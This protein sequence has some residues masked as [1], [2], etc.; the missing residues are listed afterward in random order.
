M[1]ETDVQ[2][3]P[4]LQA[5]EIDR[6]IR[7]H[8][9]HEA[10][11]ID[12][13]DLHLDTSADVNALYDRLEDRIRDSGEDKWF[14]VVNYRGNRIAPEAW[15]AHARRGKALN[16]AHS[17]GTVRYDA[18]P[19]TRA[20]IER[21]AGTEAFDANLFAHRDAAMARIAQMPSR[22]VV[23]PE[24][25]PSHSQADYEKR[26]A[27]IDAEGI[28]DVDLSGL[29]FNHSRDVNDFYDLAQEMIQASGRRWY[30]LVNY[31]GTR[32][33]PEAWVAYARRGKE[34]NEGGSLGSVRYATGSETEE[35][36]RMRAESRGFRPNVRNTRAEA[37]ERIEEM[38][39]EAQ[40]AG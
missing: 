27:F 18:S 1:T 12:L 17:M 33:M 30:F 20:R 38:K 2:T 28:F 19:E 25:A 23:R 29:A 40:A 13:S 15:V 14:F 31:N 4:V 36:I 11:E 10:M 37:L 21:E 8:R 39:A 16:Q 6:R 5:A 35:E 34:L 9:D 7:F 3:A 24:Q 26:L 22:R 32:I